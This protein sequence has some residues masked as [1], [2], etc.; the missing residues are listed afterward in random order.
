M[1]IVKLQKY[2]EWWET[3]WV[4]QIFEDMLRCCVIE[5]EDSW[6]KFLL[7]VEFAY[8]NSYKSSIKMMPYKALY[9]CK[10]W[11]SL[12][13]LE[14]SE[15]KLVGTNLMHDTEKK[16]WVIWDCLKVVSDWKKIL[17]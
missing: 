12:C 5:F 13:W 1:L 15:R 2:L 11:T 6:G 16:V 14:L 3:E 10:C 8:N 17:C 7:L 4:I 9:G